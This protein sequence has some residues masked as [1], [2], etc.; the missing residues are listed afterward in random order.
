MIGG[1]WEDNGRGYE[2]TGED[3]ME[4]GDRLW[5]RLLFSTGAKEYFR[6]QLIYPVMK[7]ETIGRGFEVLVQKPVPMVLFN[8]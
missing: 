7:R 5:Y 3:A 4:R 2:G 8:R 6:H 1:R